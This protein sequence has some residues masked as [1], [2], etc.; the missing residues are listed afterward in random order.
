MHGI[1]LWGYRD[2]MWRAQQQAT[3]VY[4]NGAEKPAL[5]WLKGYLRGTAPQV[6]GPGTAALPRAARKGTSIATFSVSGPGGASY[7]QGTNIALGLVQGGGMNDGAVV[8]ALGFAP[9]TGRLEVIN[10]LAA[11][12]YRARIYVDVDAIVSN[13]Y[14]LEIAVAE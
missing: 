8:Q 11:G 2:G 4:P 5:R 10:P 13:L 3:L 6:A 9:G 7:P 1:T 12:T 14:D